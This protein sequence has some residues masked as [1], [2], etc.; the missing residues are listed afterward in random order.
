MIVVGVSVL[1]RRWW[2]GR[3]TGLDP[4]QTGELLSVVQAAYDSTLAAFAVGGDKP[5]LFDECD[6]R[7][8]ADAERLQRVYGTLAPAVAPRLA[9]LLAAFVDAVSAAQL[10][11]M[12]FA[13]NRK[14]RGLPDGAQTEAEVE[15][16][17]AFERRARPIYAQLRAAFS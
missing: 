7:A 6:A 2:N 15:D 10:Q 16:R 17:N 11:I 3:A 1:A 9:P 8:A 14:N 4:Q 13:I 5:S 12:A